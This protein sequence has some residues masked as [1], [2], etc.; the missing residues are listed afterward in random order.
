MPN[1]WKRFQD[2]LP[3]DPTTYG[4]V[5]SHESGGDSRV[6]LPTGEVVRARGQTVTVGA[7]CWMRGGA[8]IGEAPALS[9]TEV[10]L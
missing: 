7:Y 2:L 10:D 4:E 6:E 9:Y 1:L 5:L 3:Q 8:V